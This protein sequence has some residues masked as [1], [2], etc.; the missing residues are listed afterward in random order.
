MDITDYVKA[1]T[2]VAIRAAETENYLARLIDTLDAHPYSTQTE[3]DATADAYV[4]ARAERIVTSQRHAAALVLRNQPEHTC[5]PEPV[6]LVTL[7][8]RLSE[9]PPR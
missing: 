6:D 2:D 8:A 5:E 7:L 9:L 3:R 1:A 4:R